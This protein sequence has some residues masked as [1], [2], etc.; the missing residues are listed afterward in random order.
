MRV[1]TITMMMIRKRIGAQRIAATTTML[2]LMR[3]M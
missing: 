1:K 2:L 3:V